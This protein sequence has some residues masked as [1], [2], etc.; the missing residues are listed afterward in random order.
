[1]RRRLTP[2][3]AAVAVGGLLVPSGAADAASDAGATGSTDAPTACSLAP[4]PSSPALTALR[5]TLAGATTD[6]VRLLAMGSSTTYGMDLDDPSQ[7][8][9]DRFMAGLAARGLDADPDAVSPLSRA[10]VTRSPG[11]LLVNGA[12]PGARAETYLAE[13]LPG[14]LLMRAS[15]NAPDIVLHM[16][17]SNDYYTQIP[18]AVVGASMRTTIAALDAQPDPPIHVIISTYEDPARTGAAIPWS[19]YGQEMARIAAEDPEHRVYV[20]LAPWFH[21]VEVPG[22]DPDGYLDSGGVHPSPAGHQ[23]IADLLLRALGYGC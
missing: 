3:V 18:P 13:D 12:L 19:A 9:V 23:M 16:I 15:G 8:W 10:A 2:L 5:R 6:S 20:D 7:R 1:M 4:L 17:G 11:A 22:S 14:L 21:A